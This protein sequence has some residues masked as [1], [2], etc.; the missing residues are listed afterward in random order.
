MA[1]EVR[2]TDVL[3]AHHAYHNPRSGYPDSM[4]PLMR[5]RPVSTPRPAARNLTG[6]RSQPSERARGPVQCDEAGTDRGECRVARVDAA[7]EHG[8]CVAIGGVCV[9]V[10][11]LGDVDG[12]EVV[13]RR[14]QL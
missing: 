7:G 10:A 5:T 12:G 2:R 8:E 6:P 9:G 11:A 1:C 4:A 13:E 14:S 3:V